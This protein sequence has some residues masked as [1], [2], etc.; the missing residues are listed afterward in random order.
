M[1][2]LP[3]S[4]SMKLRYAASL[5]KMQR[6]PEATRVYE[7]MAREDPDFPGILRLAL[8]AMLRDADGREAHKRRLES[9]R[10][11][12]PADLVSQ[13]LRGVLH[14]YEN[15]FTASDTLLIPLQKRLSQ[16]Q[17]LDIYLAMNAFN[18]GK[19]DEALERLNR[20]A[21]EEMPDPDIFYCRA[22]I[23]RDTKRKQAIEDLKRYLGTSERSLVAN[24]TKQTRVKALLSALEEC[25]V[26][27]TKRCT[28]EWEHP[29]LRTRVGAVG[30]S[31]GR[32]RSAE[33]E[34]QDPLVYVAIGVLFLLLLGWRLRRGKSDEAHTG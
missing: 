12:N 19:V 4:R 18:L 16:E 3:K 28:A 27:Q 25:L 14:H 33:D 20:A 9:L 29:R 34:E 5:H 1:K 31:H 23:L 10:A 2:A 26:K 11:K 13:F 17:R 24:Q 30:P 6:F 21:K 7:T 8:G 32:T 15:E 22:E